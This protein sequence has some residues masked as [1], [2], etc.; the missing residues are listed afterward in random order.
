MGLF[1]T[2][3]IF[4]PLVYL[5]ARHKNQQSSLKKRF[6][7]RV[8]RDQLTISHKDVIADR[9]IAIDEQR[10]LLLFY[11]T[12]GDQVAE[13]MINLHDAIDCTLV[14]STSEIILEIRMPG[15]MERNTLSLLDDSEDPFERGYR[16][17]YAL[18]WE[19]RISEVIDHNFLSPLKAA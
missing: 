16:L 3:V 6:E 2:G 19:R 11:R 5:A 13:Q 17:P 15:R 9:L 12:I 8:L 4:G 10:A 14:F 1:F 7:Q 18:E